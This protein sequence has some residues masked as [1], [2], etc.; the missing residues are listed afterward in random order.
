MRRRRE[1]ALQRRRWAIQ[2]RPAG[3]SSAPIVRVRDQSTALSLPT[4]FRSLLEFR[5]PLSRHPGHDADRRL[6][7]AFMRCPIRWRISLSHRR[8]LRLFED[9]A[10]VVRLVQWSARGH[11]L[12]SAEPVIIWVVGQRIFQQPQRAQAL[13]RPVLSIALMWPLWRST[14]VDK[15]PAF[16]L[17]SVAARKI[18]KKLQS[19][20]EL[21]MSPL[22]TI[23]RTGV[24]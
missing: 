21:P 8:R 9:S 17:F 13:G 2:R 16:C 1:T 10:L 19:F 18:G 20:Q 12:D 23:N 24:A 11:G 5:A 7:A 4:P 3:L 14:R 6:D 15:Q 22:T